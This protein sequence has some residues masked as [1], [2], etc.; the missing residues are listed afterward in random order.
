MSSLTK[1]CLTGIW[2]KATLIKNFGNRTTPLYLTWFLWI[3]CW[4]LTYMVL[5]QSCVHWFS[6][7][8]ILPCQAVFFFFLMTSWVYHNGEALLWT[9]P[10]PLILKANKQWPIS[11]CRGICLPRWDMSRL[12]KRPSE[13][14]NT[15]YDKRCSVWPSIA[16][17]VSCHHPH[18]LMQF[19]A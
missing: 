7:Y 2:S 4:R 18:Y 19:R 10:M 9:G 5:E 11:Q 3:D 14:Q 12:T 8:L 1:K 16:E 15:Q 17:M 6:K 13:W